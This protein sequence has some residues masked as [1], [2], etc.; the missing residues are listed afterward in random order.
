MPKSYLIFKWSVYALATFLLLALQSL[1]LNQVRILGLTPFL[2]PMLPAIVA[3][4][5]GKRRGPVFALVLGVVCDLLVS[6]PFEGFFTIAFTAAAILA[7]W[8]AETL[9][10]PGALC[11]LLV[12]ALSLLLTGGLRIAVQLLSG[13]GHLDLMARTALLEALITLPAVAVALP[14]YRAIHKRCAVDY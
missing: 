7:S 14:L 3:M 6:A 9:L 2:H 1:A 11:G 4:Y 5:E 13:G 10:A 12:S 8:I